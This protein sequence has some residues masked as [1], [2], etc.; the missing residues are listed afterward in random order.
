MTLISSASSISR[1]SKKSPLSTTFIKLKISSSVQMA[2]A[3]T[4][5]SSN[6]IL[7]LSNMNAN[8]ATTSGS[9]PTTMRME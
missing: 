8:C 2:S 7:A 9:I 4:V 6:R 3:S 5:G 1:K